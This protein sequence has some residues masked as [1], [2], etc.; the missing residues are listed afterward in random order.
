MCQAF[1]LEA[2]EKSCLDLALE[3]LRREGGE[4][5]PDADKDHAGGVQ[6]GRRVLICYGVR[7]RSSVG[8]ED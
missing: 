3:E 2:G 5:E 7:G 6:S 4:T 8:A 1:L